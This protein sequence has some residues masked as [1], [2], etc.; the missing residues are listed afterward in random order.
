MTEKS[1]GI[2]KRGPFGWKMLYLC[3]TYAYACQRRRGFQR[4]PYPVR[5]G[6]IQPDVKPHISKGLHGGKDESVGCRAGRS[7]PEERLCENAKML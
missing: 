7:F 3:T 1:E 6:Y 4:L 2:A 5:Q